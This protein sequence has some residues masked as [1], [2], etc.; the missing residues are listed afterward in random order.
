MVFLHQFGPFR[1]RHPAGAVLLS[2]HPDLT[3]FASFRTSI[4]GYWLLSGYMAFRHQARSQKR[5][6]K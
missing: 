5:Q 2:F 1:F 3:L 4:F 6:G